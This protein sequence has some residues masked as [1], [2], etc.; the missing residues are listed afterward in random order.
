MY[1]SLTGRMSKNKAKRKELEAQVL[2]RLP[3][4]LAEKLRD[5]A[6]GG[7]ITEED[8]GFVIGG[9]VT[10]IMCYVPSIWK[11]ELYEG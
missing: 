3:A 11:K 4:G 9:M 8:I 10:C 7:E 2:L 6:K 1:S 5:K